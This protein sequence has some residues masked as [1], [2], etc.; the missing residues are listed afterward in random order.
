[1]TIDDTIRTAG[2]FLPV[3]DNQIWLVQRNTEPYAGWWCAAGGK[4]DSK[5]TP[6]R[7]RFSSRM[8]AVDYEAYQDKV[9][10]MTAMEPPI[11]TA[12]AEYWEEVLTGRIPRLGVFE[13]VYT[14]G[15]VP[16]TFNGVH[17]RNY[18]AIGRAHHSKFHLS[19]REVRQ[20]KPLAKINPARIVPITRSALRHIYEAQ[21]Y[22]P[23]LDDDRSF[24]DHRVASPLKTTYRTVDVSVAKEFTDVPF[25]EPT[26][27]DVVLTDFEKRYFNPPPT[28]VPHI[29]ITDTDSCWNALLLH[30]YL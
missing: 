17:Y 29:E 3:R 18:F 1:M 24:I 20:M 25:F 5:R 6:V 13:D 9:E 10:D 30:H 7:V 19:P 11:L 12:L 23:N 15:C 16:D 27:R 26:E 28:H 2:F 22:V 4:S 8:S 14:F 21:R